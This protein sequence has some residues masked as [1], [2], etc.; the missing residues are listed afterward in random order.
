[1]IPQ[2]VIVRVLQI[3]AGYLGAVPAAAAAV[4]LGFS[5]LTSIVAD[6]DGSGVTE[7]FVFATMLIATFAALPALAIVALGE[8]MLWRNWPPY[9]IGGA[10]TG[11]L[12]PIALFG[13]TFRSGGG[14][15]T[16]LTGLASG[17]F[18]GCVYWCIAGRDAGKWKDPPP[19]P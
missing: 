9:A 13:A 2:A 4:T 1:M 3:F 19:A 16:T 12:L 18:A 14:A 11:L 6:F 15:M 10:L 7:F 5:L 17:T 8:S